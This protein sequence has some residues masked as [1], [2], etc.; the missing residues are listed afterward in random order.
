MGEEEIF[1]PAGK[2][3]LEPVQSISPGVLKEMLTQRWHK[4][5]GKLTK[6]EQ[7]KFQWPKETVNGILVECPHCGKIHE[8]KTILKKECSQCHKEFTVT[9]R[10]MFSRIKWI[11]PG[12]R[13]V[14]WEIYHLTFY[15]RLTPP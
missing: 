8:A 1:K 2:H 5:Y 7:I 15:G 4:I 9:P 12:R 11:P 3:E 6:E 10:N 14:F 13:P